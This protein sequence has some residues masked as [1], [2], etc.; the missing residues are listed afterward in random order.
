MWVTLLF[1][2]L[3]K[4]IVLKQN[5]QYCLKCVSEGKFSKARPFLT[6]YNFLNSAEQYLGQTF[7]L[8]L[9]TVGYDNGG[10]LR[11]T[12][13]Q[14]LQAFCVSVAL[15]G[16]CVCLSIAWA[17]GWVSL[18]WVWVRHILDLSSKGQIQGVFLT[19]ILLKFQCQPVR[20]FWHL[21]LWWDFLCDPILRTFSGFRDFRD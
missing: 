10:Y 19:V 1:L 21:E 17:I 18:G 2:Y 15:F 6:A 14:W 9:R 7:K 13:R 11:E 8:P 3:K 16:E 5:W 4:R 20:K 12:L